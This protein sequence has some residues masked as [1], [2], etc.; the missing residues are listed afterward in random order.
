MKKV[1][2]IGFGVSGQAISRYFIN[3]KYQVF[4]FETKKKVDFNDE[5]LQQ[6]PE[7]DFNFE[8]NDFDESN[9]DLIMISPGV[10]LDLP[11][12]IRA[13]QK[14]IPIKNDVT[15]FI[16]NWRGSGPIVGV[17][18]SNGKTT[19]VNLLYQYIKQ[20]G[21]KVVL[22]GNIGNSPLDELGKHPQ[23]TII[24]LE[25]SSYQLESFDTSHYLDI[26]LI[27]NLSSNHLDRY[28]GSMDK[29]AEAKMRGIDN[30][31][32]KTIICGDDF[33]IKKYVLPKLKA[34]NVSLVSL[35]TSS[36]QI[37]NNGVY[38][39]EDGDLFVFYDNK[40]KI[41]FSDVS[42]R[43]LVGLHNLYNI[44]MVYAILSELNINL[45]RSEIIRKFKGLEHRIEFVREINGVKY[46]N[47]SKS[48]S[49]EATRVALES[50][51]NDKNIVLILGGNDK[52][53]SFNSLVPVVEESV[54][55]IFL[56][57]GEIET[58]IK[59]TFSDLNIEIINVEN[60]EQAISR[61]NMVAQKGDVV[62][63]SPSATSFKLYKNYE[64][65]GEHFK[66]IVN[67]L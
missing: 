4:L 32:T 38:S 23:G 34:K 57:P 45:N 44:A 10:P 40:S 9:F 63:L 27:S 6:F 11:V 19:I 54:K 58:K 25:L 56:L 50:V 55:V 67:N 13:K 1:A 16:E 36:D 39:N 51:S 33:G 26:C 41:V 46:I 62:L 18:G 49:P 5:I 21:E 24:I 12:L 2:V 14:N 66:E 52:G 59:K 3:K 17:T 35:E 48:S 8:T 37:F 60:L 43:Q 7:V 64:E 47:D 28:G 20:I 15:L 42:N 53:M 31:K 61:A 30:Q 22:A 65:R 29:Y